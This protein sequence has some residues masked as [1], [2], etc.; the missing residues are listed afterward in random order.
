MRGL[1]RGKPSFAHLGKSPHR[2]AGCVLAL[3]IAL[4]SLSSPVGA[5]SSPAARTK[6]LT[7]TDTTVVRP[8][9]F[10]ITCADGYTQL[11]KTHWTTWTATQA[12]GTTDFAMNMCTPD[13]AS[14]PMSY[15]PRSTVV[16]SRP[17]DT[18]HGRLFSLL[19][20]R[21]VATGTTRTFQF[22]WRGDPSF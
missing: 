2:L 12:R 15:F 4:V 18:R 7:C 19:T 11:T 21:Y 6:L 10:V 16:L 8:T 17:V 22:S 3:G 1:F 14:S 5:V 20:V 9:E 13:C